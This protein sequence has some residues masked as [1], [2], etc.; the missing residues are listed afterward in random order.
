MILL[1]N[2]FTEAQQEYAHYS[3]QLHSSMPVMAKA[4]SCGEVVWSIL[5]V[6]NQ[7]NDSGHRSLQNSVMNAM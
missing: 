2:I 5:N 3:K 1:D 4:L 7:Y 6:V